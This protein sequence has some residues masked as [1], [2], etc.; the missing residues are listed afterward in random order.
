[1]LRTFVIAGVTCDSHLE[2]EPD[3]FLPQSACARLDRRFLEIRG[4]LENK[5][6]KGKNGKGAVWSFAVFFKTR[7]RVYFV[8]AGNLVEWIAG[9]V[10]VPVTGNQ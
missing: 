5:G 3:G 6:R 8:L 4:F 9:L 1:M 2:P 10:P 7:G